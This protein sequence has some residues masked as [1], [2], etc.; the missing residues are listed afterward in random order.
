VGLRWD[1]PLRL[2]DFTGFGVK[3]LAELIDD[4][5][6][7]DIFLSDASQYG[8][9]QQWGAW[10]RSNCPDAAGL[11]WMSRQHN[12]SSCYVFFEDTCEGYDLKVAEAAEPLEVGTRAFQ[13]LERCVSMLSWEIES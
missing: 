13:L 3:P 12:S 2:L 8:I 9:T 11:R 7:E 4:G 6:A 1:R 5:R 10:F